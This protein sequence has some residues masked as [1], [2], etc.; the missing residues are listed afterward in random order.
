L[1]TGRT[2]THGR[3]QATLRWPDA[4]KRPA[5]PLAPFVRTQPK[6]QVPETTDPSAVGVPSF[7]DIAGLER[8]V[9]DLFQQVERGG[10]G[11]IL[12]GGVA[13]RDF[14][15]LFARLRDPPAPR[16]D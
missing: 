2:N 1:E 14:Q 15:T 16:R 10:I 7:L 3:E 13:E 4:S 12:A 9:D 8:V 6:A 5:N 11:R